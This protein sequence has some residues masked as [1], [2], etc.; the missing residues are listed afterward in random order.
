MTQESPG[1]GASPMATWIA[2]LTF[3]D[4]SPEVCARIPLHLLD[5]IA[6]AAAG[7]VYADSSKSLRAATYP[8]HGPTV[9]PG[10]EYT[11]VGETGALRMDLAAFLNGAYAHSLDF[12]DTTI[13]SSLH[14]G[15]PV[16]AAALPIAEALQVNGSRLVIALAAGY[17]IACRVGEALGQSPYDRGFHP[18]GLA[19]IF[20]A[21]AAGAVLRRLDEEQTASALGIAGSM[22]SGSLQCLEDGTWNKRIHP[23]LAAR[24]ALF[25][26]DLAHADF[27]GTTDPLTGR[28]G[29]LQAFST[30]PDPSVLTAALGRDW[31]F[32]GTGVKPYPA[33]RLTH[34]AIDA[35]LE[36]RRTLS[37]GQLAGAGV[38]L[39]ISPIALDIVGGAVSTKLRPTTTVD[40]QF[41]AYFQVATALQYGNLGWGVYD[42]LGDVAVETLIDQIEITA[43]PDVATAGA[44]LAVGDEEVRIDAPSGEPD[45]D[46]DFDVVERKFRSITTAVWAPSHRDDIVS[47][48]R[49]LPAAPD[50]AEVIRLL[51]A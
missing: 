2:G 23:G 48:L 40:G 20:G 15:A 32:L 36:V 9:N 31:R 42:H 47:A 30:D 16:I 10:A 3:D 50:V 4:L 17:E 21:V 24:D 46:L 6:V 39:E 1:N 12:D 34:G 8:S 44:V 41:S 25:A 51:R 14:P 18:T 38:T 37:S 19:G 13:S 22:A 33:C 11:V 27:R 26:L 29:A 43:N 35:A 49:D 28:Y 5:F 7:K 45:G